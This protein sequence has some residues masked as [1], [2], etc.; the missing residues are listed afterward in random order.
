VKAATGTNVHSVTGYQR[1]ITLPTCGEFE[2]QFTMQM[3]VP[4]GRY[5]IEAFIWDAEANVHAITGPSLQVEVLEGAPFYGAVQMNSRWSVIKSGAAGA[6][7]I[8]SEAP[9][10]H[11]A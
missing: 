6:S 3:N 10:R 9:K 7:R 1:Q 8:K 4:A 2:Y 11:T 5:N